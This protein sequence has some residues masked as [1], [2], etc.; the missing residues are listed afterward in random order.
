MTTMATPRIIARYLGKDDIA[1]F[2]AGLD[3]LRQ[4]LRQSLGEQDVAY[5]RR[6]IRRQRL[7]EY[8]GRAA[9]H[10]GVLLPPVWLAGVGAL[11]VS[12]ILDNMEIGHNVMHGQ[13]DWSGAPDL[14]SRD[15]E[16]NLLCPEDQWRHSHNMGHHRFTNIVGQDRDVGYG[17]LRMSEAQP[18]GL[19]YLLQPF[20][21]L[22]LCLVFEWGIGL[23]D[24]ELDK[25]VFERRWSWRERKPAVRGFLRKWRRTVAKDYLLFPA[26]AGPFFL[27]VALG[28]LL[29]NA[30]RNVWAFVIIFCGH[31]PAGVEVFTPAECRGESRGEWYVRQVLGSC[32]IEGGRWLHLMSGHLSHQIEHHLFPNLPAHR[33]PEIAPAVQAL[34]RQY[35]IPYHTGSLRRQFGSVVRRLLRLWLPELPRTLAPVPA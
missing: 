27:P 9:I 5:M 19:R 29:A 26:L 17:L 16:W 31:F 21:A 35:G 10:A 15:F 25:L 22:G 18:W 7:L 20:A 2:G 8:G 34:C 33:Y 24:L 11:A 32:N 23:H 1:A 14:R 3:A 6:L 13:Y 4:R 30:G 12:K 28:N